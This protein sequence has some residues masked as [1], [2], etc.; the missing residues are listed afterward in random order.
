MTTINAI[1]F[2]MDGLIFDT[3]AL[4][5]RAWDKAGLEMGYTDFGKNLY[6]NLGSNRDRE[7]FA[8]TYGKDFPYDEFVQRYETIIEEELRTKGMP[9]KPGLIPLLQ[10]LKKNNYQLAIATSS[11]RALTKRHLT[12][13]GIE[14]Y[15]SQI[16]C[17]DMITHSKPDPEIYLKACEALDVS[18]EHALVLE[19]SRNGI[20]AA[21]AAKIPVIMIPDLLKDFPEEEPFLAAK[22]DSLKD[23]IAWLEENNPR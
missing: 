20:R 3:E 22:L 7:Y 19:D 14:S 2:D 21:L 17:G 8:E 1:L 13:A 5:Y 18:P 23:V 4:K 6:P 12:Q 11:D 10:Y 15:F 9:Q 16:I